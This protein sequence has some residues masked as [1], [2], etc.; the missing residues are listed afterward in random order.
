[1]G[2][3]SSRHPLDTDSQGTAAH[4]EG[5]TE[6]GAVPAAAPGTTDLGE[7]ARSAFD[8]GFGAVKVGVGGLDGE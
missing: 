2:T 1:M 6:T 5:T 3:W 7:K 4:P 8:Y